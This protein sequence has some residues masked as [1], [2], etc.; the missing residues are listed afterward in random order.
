MRLI[1][2]LTAQPEFGMFSH[3]VVQAY[4]KHKQRLIRN[5]YIRVKPADRDKFGIS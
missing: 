2:L 4:L 1:L 5:I 3:E